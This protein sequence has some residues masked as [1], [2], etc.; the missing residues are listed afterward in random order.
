MARKINRPRARIDYHGLPGFTGDPWV[1]FGK[2]L[3]LVAVLRPKF[4]IALELG[5]CVPDWLLIGDVGGP[6]N[7]VHVVVGQLHL[8]GVVAR[9]LKDSVF[10]RLALYSADAVF[11]LIYELDLS[12][13]HHG[14]PRSVTGDGQSSG[15][16]R[17]QVELGRT[18]AQVGHSDRGG[19]AYRFVMVLC[20]V[21][22]SMAFGCVPY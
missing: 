1:V 5:E 4:Q 20:F 15:G 2:V 16:L 22:C 21:A 17:G 19:I 6:N 14:V 13:F 9:L 8:T 3:V 11:E 10:R 18:V 7:P 12:D